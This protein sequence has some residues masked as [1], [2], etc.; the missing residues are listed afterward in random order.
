[1]VTGKIETQEKV[2]NYELTVIFRGDLSEEKL[3]AAVE[4]V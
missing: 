4:N 1:M 2:N 3:T